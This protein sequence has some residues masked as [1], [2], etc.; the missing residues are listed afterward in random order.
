MFVAWERLHN[1][2]SRQQECTVTHTL[3]VTSTVFPHIIGV[4]LFSCPLW[5]E[6]TYYH[7]D[8][9]LYKTEIQVQICI[10]GDYQKHHSSHDL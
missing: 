5:I 2:I 9:K 7:R 3:H 1:L 10:K 6:M 8:P 4:C